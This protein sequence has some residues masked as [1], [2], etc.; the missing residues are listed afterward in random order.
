LAA[1]TIVAVALVA[2]TVAAAGNGMPVFARPAAYYLA[3]GDSIAYGL[4][5]DKVDA[6]LPP[7]KFDTGYVDV[8]A[9][10]MRASSPHLRVVNYGCPGE[11]TTTFLAGGCPWLADRTHRLH[12]PFHG[13][14][15]AAALAFLR[16]H[17]GQVNPI[18]VTLASNDLS[19]FENACHNDL[20][21]VRARAPR[22]I[23]AFASRL[24]TILE[25]LRTADPGAEII[26]TGLWS[27][28]TLTFHQTDPLLRT[29]NATMARVTAAARGRFVDLFPVFDPQSA[30]A[31]RARICALTYVCSRADGHPTNAGY[32]AIAAAVWAASGYSK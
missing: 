12:D 5:P 18:T 6:G 8:F 2:T 14:Q 9:A 19:A 28:D 16:A 3:L 15:M 32:R 24:S 17:R 7:S 30:A 22:A 25:R 23:A 1:G 31:R 10:R 21:C 4:Q 13:A 27:G 11:S 26:V 20:G 29:V